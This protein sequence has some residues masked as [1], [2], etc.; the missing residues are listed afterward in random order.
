MESPSNGFSLDESPGR[1][2]TARK[3]R[4]SQGQGLRGAEASKAEDGGVWGGMPAFGRFAIRSLYLST[5]ATM[6]DISRNRSDT[7][8]HL[9][10]LLGRVLMCRA[11]PLVQER[12]LPT[13]Q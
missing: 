8:L 11:K 3:L 4:R 1:R 5:L 6:T 9:A 7:V 10:L 13:K 12:E 2:V